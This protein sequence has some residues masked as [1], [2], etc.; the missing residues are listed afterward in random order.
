MNPHDPELHDPELLARYRRASESH[1]A[2]P[3]EAS[4][5][6]IL[7]E[8]RRLA[9]ANA[10][11]R[12]HQF[13]RQVPVANQSRWRLAALGTACSVLIVG[14]L[15]IPQ[16]MKRPEERLVAVDAV[17]PPAPMA[18]APAAP[19]PPKGDPPQ[20]AQAYE[21]QK[22][23]PASISAPQA[24]RPFAKAQPSES[25]R[26]A[27]AGAAADSHEDHLASAGLSPADGQVSGH[28]EAANAGITANA[29]Q[30]TPAAQAL[31]QSADEKQRDRT[32]T[33][34]GAPAADAGDLNE[35]VVTG[36]KASRAA[37]ALSID[38]Q[39][40]T[41]LH[42]AVLEENVTQVRELLAAGADPTALD[43]R[44]DTPLTLARQR[45]LWQILDLLEAAARAHLGSQ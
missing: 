22:P 20:V 35:V 12:P 25:T 28:P 29:S 31:R 39:G 36:A 14:I 7:T 8:A 5:E 16:F 21:A 19:P 37:R 43:N 24:S 32:Q 17:A 18:L 30:A 23:R 4:R 27:G 9:N 15:V 34:P 3:T 1:E 10:G 11:A 6:A 40:R 13:D 45:H 2:R 41:A 26:A 44:G 33:Q 38:A 42:R